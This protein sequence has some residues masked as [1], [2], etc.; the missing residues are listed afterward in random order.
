[1]D[2][3]YAIDGGRFEERVGAEAGRLG[4]RQYVGDNAKPAFDK[5]RALSAN[6]RAA[7]FDQAPKLRA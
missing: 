6:R 4:S 5:R 3:G 1:M 7:V 2:G